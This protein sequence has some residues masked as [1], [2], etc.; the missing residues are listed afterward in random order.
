MVSMA[1][2]VPERL[3]QGQQGA[4]V[5]QLVRV[6]TDH[7]S[8]PPPKPIATAAQRCAPTFSPRAGPDRAVMN[9][10]AAKV[11]AVKAVSGIQAERR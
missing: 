9:S 7:R 10:G 11:M 4:Q 3:A 2:A 8:A 1:P 6:G 5:D